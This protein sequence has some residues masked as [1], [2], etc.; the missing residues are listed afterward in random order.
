MDLNYFVSFGTISNTRDQ[1]HMPPISIKIKEIPE[2]FWGCGKE[3]DGT[4]ANFLP[5]GPPEKKLT[6]RTILHEPM[7]ARC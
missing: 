1:C 7:A 5:D 4:G 3:I 2:I 6:N